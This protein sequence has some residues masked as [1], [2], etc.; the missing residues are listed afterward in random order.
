MPTRPT[1][2][3]CIL[4]SVFCLMNSANSVIQKSF[5]ITA[6]GESTR[7][8]AQSRITNNNVVAA[9]CAFLLA[10]IVNGS[11]KLQ[12]VLILMLKKYELCGVDDLID[13]LTEFIELVFL[14]H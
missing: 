5:D 4:L 2:V 3:L 9:H 13:K 6:E 10:W 8:T 7:L 14:L 1:D 11:S 12:A